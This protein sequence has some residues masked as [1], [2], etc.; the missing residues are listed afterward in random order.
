MIRS[1][2]AV[3][4]FVLLASISLV[5][6]DAPVVMQPNETAYS[7]AD[8]AAL[9]EEIAALE[10]FLSNSPLASR[11]TFAP[12]EW[13]SADFAAYTAGILD[14]AGYEPA[15][16]SSSGWEGSA[17]T[18]LLVGVPVG[19]TTAWIPV[20]ASP[21]AG[22]SQ[23]ILGHVPSSTNASG[24]T[25]FEEPYSLFDSVVS[26]SPN[27]P[28]VATIRA[29]SLTV[30]TR[31]LLRFYSIGSRDP[32][33]VVT[34]YQWDFGDGE[35]IETTNTYARHEFRNPGNFHVTLTVFDNRGERAS[36]QIQLFAAEPAEEDHR[37][38]ED[39]SGGC[40]SCGG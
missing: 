38:E 16:V 8:V 4:A 9:S 37:R 6:A 23:Q 33:G 35:I 2:V 28:P 22:Q 31:D 17:H 19:A 29:L 14:G 39:T 21:A 30:E 27:L 10:R 34:L 13:Q 11:R 12:N 1:S 25:W 20:E 26:L 40:S 3:V 24:E 15:L 5:G 36:A 32:D 18:W 7:A